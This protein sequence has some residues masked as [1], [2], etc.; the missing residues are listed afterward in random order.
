MGTSSSKVNASDPSRVP[1]AGRVAS[2]LRPDAWAELVRA[3]DQWHHHN[4]IYAQI[5]FAF[6]RTISCREA[7]M[8]EQEKGYSV[9]VKV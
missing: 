9:S 7:P 4:P 2:A 3:D 8:C 6:R 5:V 1:A